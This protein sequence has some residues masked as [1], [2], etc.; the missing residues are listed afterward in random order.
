VKILVIENAM[1]NFVSGARNGGGLNGGSSD[2]DRDQ[3]W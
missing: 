1:G 2:N 3:L